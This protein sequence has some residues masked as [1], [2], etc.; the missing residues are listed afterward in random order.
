MP[1]PMRPA[2]EHAD[3]GRGT[4]RGRRSL[5]LPLR[6]LQELG[7]AAELLG[8]LEELGLRLE[9]DGGVRRRAARGTRAWCDRG[10]AGRCA[11]MR[12][13]I[14]WAAAQQLVGGMQL[15]D[16]ADRERLVGVDQHGR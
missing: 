3:V 4:G 11:A 1:A 16:E 13:A 14:A 12:S 10:G 7:H 8:A 15:G 9:V 2:A 6:S 5:G